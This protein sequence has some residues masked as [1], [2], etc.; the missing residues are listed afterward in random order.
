MT[1]TKMSDLKAKMQDMS[2]AKKQKKVRING[3][4]LIQH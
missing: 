4:T 3:A 1:M 2:L